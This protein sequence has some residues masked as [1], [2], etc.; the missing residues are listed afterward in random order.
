LRGGRDTDTDG[1]DACNNASGRD[2]D[3]NSPVDSKVVVGGV[4]VTK[5]GGCDGDSGNVG[6]DSGG[7]RGEYGGGGGEIGKDADD[8][9]GGR[10]SSSSSSMN[11]GG[12]ISSSSPSL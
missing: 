9:G 10:S 8:D 4:G 11:G 7:G 2:D 3:G 6:E 12:G 5:I 1:D